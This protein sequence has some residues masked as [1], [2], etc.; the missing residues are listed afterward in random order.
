MR[1]RDEFVSRRFALEPAGRRSHGDGVP[2]APGSSPRHDHRRA[3]TTRGQGCI[4][5]CRASAAPASGPRWASRPMSSS[6]RTASTSTLPP[7]GDPRDR[8]VAPRRAHERALAASRAQGLHQRRREREQ[9]NG[10][11]SRLRARRLRLQAADRA[12]PHARRSARPDRRFAGLTL[13]NFVRNATG[14][15]AFPTCWSGVAG[16]CATLRLHGMQAPIDVVLSANGRDAYVASKISGGLA[17]LTRDANG[18]ITQPPFACLTND[19]G[20]RCVQAARSRARRMWRSPGRPRRLPRRLRPG[21]DQQLFFRNP[22]TPASC[23]HSMALTAASPT[24]ARRDL[25]RRRVPR[26]RAG[27][28]VSPDGR[29]ASTVS[30][31]TTARS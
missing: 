25:Q 1:P 5:S 28:V 2:A 24:T 20:D 6:V 21:R 22:D 27:I 26:G 19:G 7:S 8:R 15:L 18:S 30:R 16:L 9:H 31:R 12:D 4:A 10:P 3:L 29:N 13:W 17:V 14:A 23:I 11:A